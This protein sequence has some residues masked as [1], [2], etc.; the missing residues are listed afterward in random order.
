MVG[1]FTTLLIL[2]AALSADLIIET[3]AELNAD[4]LLD[5]EAGSIVD[6]ARGPP[7]EIVNLAPQVTIRWKN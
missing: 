4:I 5:S 1:I 7:A 2:A 3:T 6:I